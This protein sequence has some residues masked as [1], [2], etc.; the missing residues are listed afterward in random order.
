MKKATLEKIKELQSFDWGVIKKALDT[1][2]KD[3][4]HR[5]FYGPSGYPKEV[6]DRDIEELHNLIKK[7]ERI[8]RSYE[9][10]IKKLI[11]FN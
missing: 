5:R 1:R 8:K 11:K 4:E 7:I 3:L 10:Q 9:P 2:L 6:M